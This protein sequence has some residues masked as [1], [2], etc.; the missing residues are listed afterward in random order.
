MFRYWE[1]GMYIAKRHENVLGLI[2]MSSV[3]MALSHPENIAE[4][5]APCQIDPV[6]LEVQQHSGGTGNGQGS[7]ERTSDN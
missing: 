7:A 1:G 6:R 3:L 2:R 5:T 4:P